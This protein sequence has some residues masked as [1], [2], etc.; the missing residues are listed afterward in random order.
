MG[1]NVALIVAGQFVK[2]VS[3]TSA[4][5]ADPWAI[6]LK[7]LMGAV[8]ASGSVILAAHKYLQDTVVTPQEAAKVNGKVG[9]ADASAKKKDKPRL[10]LGES[11]Q[12]LASSRYI[13]DI[14][15]LVISYGLCINIVEVSWKS[16]LKALCPDPNSYSAFMGNF[17]SVTGV[18]TLSMMLFGRFVLQRF[19]YRAAALIT[20]TVL[21]V[22]G[23]GFYATNM[24]P[25]I[26]T[27]LA[28]MFGTTPLFLAVMIG[29]VQ[30]IM[31][32]SSKYSLFDPCK[33]MAY[34]PLDKDSKTKGKAA[35]DVVGAP[36]GKSGSSLVQQL[37]I[38]GTG[39]LVASTP[40]LAA[41]LSMV[42]LLWFKSAN[43]LATQFEEAM[44]KNEEQ[45]KQQQAA[46]SVN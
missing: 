6:S 5:A 7:Y 24:F 16:R 36:L 46:K 4:G 21:G 15:I 20:P 8:V 31:S 30:N 45:Q 11:I 2:W 35:I 22:T 14:A 29:S 28:S 13:R 25:S 1:A 19:G 12:F 42:V 26:S 3:S 10:S 17:A 9:A 40:Y 27:P 23:L 39:S 37:L 18:V 34:I 38:L 33:E 41:I 44:K 43:S 32:K